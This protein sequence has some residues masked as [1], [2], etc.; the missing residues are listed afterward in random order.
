MELEDARM[1]LARSGKPVGVTVHTLRRQGRVSGITTNGAPWHTMKAGQRVHLLDGEVDRIRSLH[2]DNTVEYNKEA[3]VIYGLLREAWESCIE[4][5]LLYN[6]V[7]RYRNSVHTLKLKEVLIEDDD[8]HQIDLHMAKAST[9]MTGHDKSKALHDDRP[10]PDEL[11]A[12]INSLREFSKLV[13]GRREQTRERRK[14]Q[15]EPAAV[16]AN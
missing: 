8:I 5:D 6:V 16:S 11:L 9:W 12:D 15:L 7:C 1:A 14:K 2:S 3:A 13:I 4:D 10:G